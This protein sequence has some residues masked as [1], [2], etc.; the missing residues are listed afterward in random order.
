MCRLRLAVRVCSCFV[1]LVFGR[2]YGL[3]IPS[4]MSIIPHP[5]PGTAYSHP[6]T[7]EWA[8]WFDGVFEA[9][10]TVVPSCYCC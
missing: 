4:A 6:E 9:T 8:A 3:I 10:V 2:I 1:H 7:A 5:F